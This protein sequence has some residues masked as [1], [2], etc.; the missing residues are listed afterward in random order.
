MSHFRKRFAQ[1]YMFPKSMGS[2]QCSS[3]HREV[4]G[5]L[6]W[7]TCRESGDHGAINSWDRMPFLNAFT[8]TFSPLPTVVQK[9]FIFANYGASQGIDNDDGS[10]FY[11]IT[12]NVFY[13]ADGSRMASLAG[14]LL[15]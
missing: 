3:V 7:N 6:I 8:G 14:S 1:R 9:N 15:P 4:E 10:A 12:N 5:N 2:P 11:E 13:N